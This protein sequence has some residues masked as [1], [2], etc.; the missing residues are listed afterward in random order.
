MA[1]AVP[2]ALAPALVDNNVIDYSQATGQKLY[3][4][5]I[6]ALQDPYDG[7]EADLKVFLKQLETRAQ[8]LGWTF[9][10][11]VPRDLN[12][13]DDTINILTGYGCLTMEQVRA[14]AATYINAQ[15]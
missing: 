6:E 13:P 10:L 4:S 5:A 9:I 15:N 12:A 2:F 1:A 3:K 14:H 8:M 11:D 7:Q